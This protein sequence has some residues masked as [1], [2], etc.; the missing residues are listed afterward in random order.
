[1]KNRTSFKLHATPYFHDV[2]CPIHRDYMIELENGWFGNPVWW[3]KE[4]KKPYQLE[5]HAL[6]QWNQEKVDEQLALLTNKKK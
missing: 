2:T 4:C 3:C 1:M 6:R 5:L